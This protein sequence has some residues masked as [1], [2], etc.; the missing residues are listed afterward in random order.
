[1]LKYTHFP[2]F[3]PHKSFSVS[4]LDDPS[5]KPMSM[6]ALKCPQLRLNPILWWVLSHLPLSSMQWTAA[7]LG[8]ERQ[9]WQEMWAR[10]CR[11]GPLRVSWAAWVIKGNHN[12]MSFIMRLFDGKGRWTYLM[13]FFHLLHVCAIENEAYLKIL[14]IQKVLKRKPHDSSDTS[15]VH[16]IF[17]GIIGFCLNDL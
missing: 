1:M 11:H 9:G 14:K 3:S 8:P 16:L 17:C 13:S 12:Y 2:F 10:V 5:L 7:P 15:S 4:G 6:A